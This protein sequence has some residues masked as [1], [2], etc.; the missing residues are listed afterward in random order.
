ME[1]L[2]PVEVGQGPV[3]V[4][5]RSRGQAG[6]PDLETETLRGDTAAQPVPGL[7]L[8]HQTAGVT[9]A[10][11]EQR[12]RPEEPEDAA[13]RIVLGPGA[14]AR[15]LI[16]PG[17]VE[18]KGQAIL[19]VDPCLPVEVWHEVI[20]QP[21]ETITPLTVIFLQGAAH[22]ARSAEAGHVFVTGLVQGVLL[23]LGICTVHHAQQQEHRNKTQQ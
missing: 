15:S 22:A 6:V 8:V 1:L 3:D 14:F 12:P 16:Q 4:T 10:T 20:L 21:F 7:D 23:A 19:F 13:R 5:E 11:I 2:L 17:V 18:R 9:A